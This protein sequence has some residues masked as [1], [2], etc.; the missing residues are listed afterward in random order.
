MRKKVSAIPVNCA[1]WLGSVPPGIFFLGQ[2]NQGQK[3]HLVMG[4]HQVCA[5]VWTDGQHRMC[6]I[7]VYI[8]FNGHTVVVLTIHSGFIKLLQTQNWSHRLSFEP[9]AR[10]IVLSLSICNISGLFTLKN[11]SFN[12]HFWSINLEFSGQWNVPPCLNVYLPHVFSWRPFTVFFAPEDNRQNVCV[13]LGGGILD[14]RLLAGRRET[15]QS[16]MKQ[17]GKGMLTHSLR[18]ATR[19]PDTP[20]SE[21][22][23]S[24][25]L[26][27][28]GL[29]KSREL[30]WGLQ[31]NL[32]KFAS[33]ERWGLTWVGRYVSGR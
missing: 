6:L 16:S 33:I 18:A 2:S 17:M 31:R 5:G 14:G 11:T 7:F 20:A 32:G 26:W 27:T 30:T 13:V 19:A 3:F 24:T 10:Y 1:Q 29:Q 9:L 12:G 15:W 21:S 25:A 8:P 4:E 22:W 23:D 28:R